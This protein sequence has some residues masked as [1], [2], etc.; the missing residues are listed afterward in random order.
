MAHAPLSRLRERGTGR[1]LAEAPTK[2][3]GIV[4]LLL[5]PLL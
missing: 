2:L 1:E 3:I 4:A 5:V